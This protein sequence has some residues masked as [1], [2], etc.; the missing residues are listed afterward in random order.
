MR[1][2]LGLNV[3]TDS[4]LYTDCVTTF[5]TAVEKALPVIYYIGITAPITTPE[6]PSV[7]VTLSHYN[8]EMT[9]THATSSLSYEHEGEIVTERY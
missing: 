8:L 2:G 5:I 4:S 3:I 7:Q 6:L 9:V 1:T